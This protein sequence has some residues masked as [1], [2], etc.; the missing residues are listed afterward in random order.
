MYAAGTIQGHDI[1]FTIDTGAT[2]TIVSERWLK[3]LP[4][5]LVPLLQKRPPIMNAD[6]SEIQANL[7][8]FDVELGPFRITSKVIVA[9]I[10]DDALLGSDILQLGPSG[11]ADIFLSKNLMRIGDVDIP[12]FL[13]GQHT[14]LRQVTAAETCTIPAMSEMIIEAMVDTEGLEPLEASQLVIEPLPTFVGKSQTLLAT[15]VVNARDNVT[16]KLRIINPFNNAAMVYQDTVMGVAQPLETLQFLLDE[17]ND[18]PNELTRLVNSE[19]RADISVPSHVQELFQTSTVGCNHQGQHLLAGLLT[20][21]EDIFSKDEFDL[22]LTDITEHGI[23]TGEAKP[24]KQPPRRLPLAFAGEELK[25]LEKLQRQGVIR[26]SKASPWASPIVMVRKKDGSVRL[27][28]DLRMVNKVTTKDAFP[29]PRIQDCLDSL[30]GA[31]VFSTIDITSAYNQIPVKPADICKTAFV[32]RYGH[33]EHV[34]MPF[35]LCNAPATFQRMMEMALN[36]LQWTTCLIYLDDVIIFSQTIQENID[37]LRLVFDRIRK[38]KLKLKPAKCSLLRSDVTFLGHVVS[39]NGVNPN[40][41]NIDKI[42]GWPQPARVRDVR[43]FLGMSGYYRRFVKDYS[44]LAKPLTNLTRKGVTFCWTTPCEDAFQKLKSVLVSPEVMAF[45]TDHC[46]FILDTDACDVSIGAVLSQMQG[47]NERVIAYASRTLN[48]AERNYCVTDRELLAVKHFVEYFRQYLLGRSFT[49]RSDHQALVWLFSLKEPKARVARWIEIL[50]A[51][52]FSIEHRAGNKHG[53][54]DGISRCPNPRDCQCADI[55]EMEPLKCGPCKKCTKRAQDMVSKFTQDTARLTGRTHCYNSSQ[56]ALPTWRYV[57]SI[58]WYLWGLLTVSLHLCNAQ[59]CSPMAPIPGLHEKAEVLDAYEREM[60]GTIRVHSFPYLDDGRMVPTTFEEIISRETRASNASSVF[61]KYNSATL[62]RKQLNDV[63][64]API[65][66]W[67]EDNTRPNSQTLC[68]ASS[69]TRHYLV[70]WDSLIIVDGVLYRRFLRKDGT[71]T[72]T[73]LIVPGSM[74]SDVL[75][76]MHNNVLSGHLGHKK[77]KAKTLQRFYWC[78]LQP[79]VRHWVLACD[80]C[81]AIKPPSK[82]PRAPLGDMRV[83]A[84]LDRL[85]MDILGP[86]PLTTRGNKYILVISDYFTNWVEVLPIPDQKAETC[87]RVLLNEVI[88][89]YGCPLDLHTDQGT[90][91]TSNVIKELCELL[92]IRKTKTS[93]RNPRCNGKVERF[94][95]TLIRMIKSFIKGEQH[96]WD[97][98]LGCL[99]AAYRSTPH[100]MVNLT[101]NMLM[102]GREVRMPGEVLAI[103]PKPAEDNSESYCANYVIEL[104][105]KLKLAHDICRIHLKRTSRRTKQTYDAKVALTVYTRGDYVWYLTELKSADECPKLQVAYNG[106]YLVLKMLSELDYLIQFDAGG[107]KKVIHHNKLKPYAGNVNLKWRLTALRRHP[108]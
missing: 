30:S 3:T 70:Y 12:I 51:Y 1:T 10:H 108:P 69:I 41:T 34:T 62:R 97:A 56:L 57:V 38:T 95:R 21:Y 73:Q 80:V 103:S 92:E 31:S 20:E 82:H 25:T 9:D 65:L 67:K 93:P 99:S 58:I 35:G 75:C 46:P 89:R 15:A 91:F 74:K 43:A 44:K 42:C 47:G 17:P 49:V 104:R 79:D 71:D 87:A 59:P 14:P 32:S 53:N 50:S 81:A 101:P 54:A 23:D 29:L 52:N 11:P 60:T 55:D 22:G 27:C 40:P 16:V 83:G 64:I 36:G 63:D 68:S 26:P 6:G 13:I 24:I 7:G 100:E 28:T 98:Y 96:N 77:T 8:V 61:N 4:A 107:R 66:H 33:F 86:L 48:K 106:P 84:P 76:Q 78:G 19:E 5:G 18:V 72:Y 85:A 45:P 105:E 2:K 88:A 39:A 37:K 90:N 94:N 102:L